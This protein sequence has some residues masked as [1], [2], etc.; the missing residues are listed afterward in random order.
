MNHEIFFENFELL[1]DVPNSV[2]KLRKLIL[3]LAVKGKLVPQDPNEKPTSVLLEKIIVEKERLIKEN[4]LKKFQTL[5]KIEK[6]EI[7]FEIP[8]TWKWV[9]FGEVTINRD[10]ERIPLSKDV[11]ENHKKIYDYYGASGVIDKVEDYIFNKPLLLIGEDGANLLN[12]STPIAFIA[13]GK[14]WV[15]NHAHV[16]DSISFDC[17]RYLEVFINAI[18][19]SAYITGT[20]QPKMNQTKMNSIL[21]T[22]PPL[23]EQKRIV[24]KVDQLM[25]L[26]DELEARQQKKHEQRICLNNAALDKLLTALTPEEFAQYWQRICDNFDLLYDVPETVGQLRQAILQLGV[27][28]KLVAQDEGD[29]P[30]AVLVEKIKAEKERLI[31]QG[32]IKK[33]KTPSINIEKLPFPL[34]EGWNWVRLGTLCNL[35]TKGS[36][37]KWQGVKYVEPG[38]GILFITSENVRNYEVN[39]EKSKYVQEIFNEIEPRSILNQNDILMNIV[40]ASIGRTAIYGRNEIANI[41]QAVCLIRVIGQENLLN[42]KYLLYFFNSPVCISFMFD[43]QV[44]NARANLS[45]GNISKFPIP[46]PPLEEQNR[47]VAK[48]DNFMILCNELEAGLMQAQ[49]EGGK[50]MEAVVHHVL[51]E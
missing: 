22:F 7:P 16:L 32:K 21:V 48:L 44:D 10:S 33:S 39:L 3:Q 24:A 5:S 25:A 37:P 26:C 38:N 11:R 19:L 30:A 50:L 12:R 41:N 45:M 23:D 46:L 2:G 51:A 47:I 36:S 29:E 15:N 20:A 34:P 49:T 31:Q 6:D 4:K 27:Q 9:R 18:D 17:L 28:G 35:I 13:E 43:K 42:L 14:Y 1:V 40:G 8:K